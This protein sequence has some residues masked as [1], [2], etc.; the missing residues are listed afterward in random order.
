LKTLP[1]KIALRALSHEVSVL[2]KSSFPSSI[3]SI[4]VQLED[5]HKLFLK[6]LPQGEVSN[7]ILKYHP[8]GWGCG[9]EVVWDGLWSKGNPCPATHLEIPWL[10]FTLSSRLT[11]TFW[12]L[13][14]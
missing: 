6:I 4:K 14:S 13:I 11:N 1:K 12:D 8:V 9:R 2:T 10:K 7:T 5:V 3:Y